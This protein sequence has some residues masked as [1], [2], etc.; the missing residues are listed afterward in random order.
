M[1][2]Y[3]YLLF[4]LDGTVIDN[5]EGVYK[6]FEYALNHYGIMVNNLEELS[7]V[8]GPPLKTSF[9]E[10]YG[11]SAEKATEAVAKYRER[12]SVTGILEC[13]VYEGIKE[14]FEALYNRGYKL[15]LATSKP[16]VYARR[17][18][19]HF[20]LDKYF[21][22]IAGAEIGGKMSEKEDVLE[23]IL[24]SIDQIDVSDC[25]MIGDRKYDLIGAAQFGMDAMGVLYGFG[26]A[27]E[28][29]AYPSVAIA[30]TVEDIGKILP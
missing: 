24:K 19:S 1:K 6:S 18:L 21:Y 5:S 26:D 23:H 25:L 30:E 10:L 16:E 8:I 7:P 11:F 28:L 17:I 12:Y 2:Q 13:R 20:E 27:K 4:D 29:G 15:V 22:F 14:L 3:K 9:M